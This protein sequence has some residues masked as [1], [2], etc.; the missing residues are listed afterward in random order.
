MTRPPPLP[1]PL[2]CA[3]VHVLSDLGSDL[4]WSRLDAHAIE[5]GLPATEQLLHDV[6]VEL[7]LRDPVDAA[8]SVARLLDVTENAATLDALGYAR[9]TPCSTAPP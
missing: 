6:A 7:G 3:A 1:L 2:S 4:D 9:H 5:H 8:R